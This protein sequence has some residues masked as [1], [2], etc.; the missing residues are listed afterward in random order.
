M[1]I[2]FGQHKQDNSFG[3]FLE[4][5]LDF[6]INPIEISEEKRQEILDKQSQGWILKV[7]EKGY[8]YVEEKPE[9]SLDE[10]KNLKREE[11]NAARNAEEQGGFP[12]K[13]KV[14]D[15]DPISCIRIS[16]AAQAMQMAAMAEDVPVITWTCQDNS[17]IDLT[18][19]DLM[20]LVV[21]LAEWSNAC[22]QKATQIKTLLEECQTPEE[23]EKIS[24]DMSLDVEEPEPINSSDINSILTK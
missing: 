5:D 21:A 23:V 15:S 4:D 7:D 11:I 17:T 9:P 1:K 20:G 24:W 14:F 22:H 13:G 19:P 8:P 18:A 3:F 10:L 2:F 12:Y 6:C 16:S